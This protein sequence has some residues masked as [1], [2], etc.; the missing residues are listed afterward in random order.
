I[1]DGVSVLCPDRFT[2]GACS[3]IGPRTSI[4]CWRFQAGDYL[5]ME[6]DVI[7]GRGSEFSTAE[8]T[9]TMGRA[10]FVGTGCILNTARAITIGDEVGIGARV[11][12]WTHGAYLPIDE[13]FPCTF[14]P[15]T[16]GNKVWLTGQSQVLPGVTIGG[17][18]FDFRTRD[19]L[20]DLTNAAEDFRDFCRRHGIRFLTGKPFFSLSHP[21]VTK[22]EHV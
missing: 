1:G 19:V 15:V 12:I 22:W 2:L 17:A 9:L 18:A 3:S 5:Y 11:G 4:R 20:G 13:G 16:I 8:S 14:G 6:E 21:D 7:V 10:V